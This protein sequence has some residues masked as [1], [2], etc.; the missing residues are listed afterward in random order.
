MTDK[1]GARPEAVPLS[2]LAPDDSLPV[3][4]E[5]E[6]M[7]LAVLPWRQVSYDSESKRVVVSIEM[8]ST[9]GVRGVQIIE[10]DSLVR[11]IIR[12]DRPPLDP[13]VPVFAVRRVSVAAVR[14]PSPL[15]DRQLRD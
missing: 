14:L 12:G 13:S 10:T 9:P 11:L 15:G 3:L 1:S 4:T 8:T 2:S 6:A 7:D 5:D